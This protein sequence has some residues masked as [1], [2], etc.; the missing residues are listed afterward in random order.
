MYV[1]YDEEPKPRT[2]CWTLARGL[3]SP[4][5]TAFAWRWS[6]GNQNVRMIKAICVSFGFE[7][8]DL[9]DAYL[10]EELNERRRGVW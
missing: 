2:A 9:G 5:D 8:R 3:V 4:L 6:Y 10:L 7:V 1:S